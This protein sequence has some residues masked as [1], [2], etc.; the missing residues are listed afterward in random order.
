VGKE[1]E[2][3]R[4]NL[5]GHHC[6]SGTGRGDG[7]SAVDQRTVEGKQYARGRGAYIPAQ[8]EDRWGSMGGSTAAMAP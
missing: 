4:R 2:A 3:V 6:G 5:R 1:G 8:S 7:G